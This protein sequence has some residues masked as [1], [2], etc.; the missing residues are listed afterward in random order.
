VRISAGEG[1]V[2]G[3][4]S[5][6]DL[7]IFVPTGGIG[8]VV[9]TVRNGLNNQSVTG[10]KLTTNIGGAALSVEGA[11]VM[12][13]AAGVCAAT[14]E[15]DNYLTATQN[16][17]TINE[18]QETTVDF[19]LAP[20]SLPNTVSIATDLIGPPALNDTVEIT[21][22]TTGE[23]TPLYYRMWR[24]TQYGAP[25]AGSWQRVTDDWS[26]NNRAQWIPDS[27]DNSV[28]VG[29]ITNDTTRGVVQQAGLTIETS[30]NSANTVQIISFTA[31]NLGSPHAPGT[32]VTFTTEATGGTGPLSYEYWQREG[33]GG[34]WSRIQNY[35]L[36]NT[37]V[38]NPTK[39]GVYTVVGKATDDRTMQFPPQAGMTCIVGE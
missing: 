5:N 11:Y 22:T 28:V 35:S 36:D 34:S 3:A 25:G 23:I 32:P 4:N 17:V 20:D 29:H 7:A 16:N 38:W 24:L 18:G 30:G 6:Y 1:T 8:I 2:F 21:I 31:A 19:V 9:G 27:H 13:S 14:A 39:A 10:A 12:V 37:C 26:E 15:A 33:V